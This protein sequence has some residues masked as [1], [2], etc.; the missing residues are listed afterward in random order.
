MLEY[1]YMPQLR[2]SLLSIKGKCNYCSHL[3]ANPIE[4]KMSALPRVRTDINLQPFQVTGLDCAGP[5]IIYA[6]NGHQKKAW[7]LILT[8]TVTRFIKLY[9]LYSM[10]SEDIFEALMD[11][12]HNFGPVAQFISDN[13]TNS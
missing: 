13:G 8:C 11:F 10:S 7:I 5:Y 6:K 3:R 9:V 12:W 4:Y 2:Q 1:I